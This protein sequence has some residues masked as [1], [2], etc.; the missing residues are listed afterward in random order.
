[1][2]FSLFVC[3][4]GLLGYGVAIR[5]DGAQISQATIQQLTADVTE[6]MTLTAQNANFDF[7]SAQRLVASAMILQ[8]GV[9]GSVTIE[10]LAAT[11]AM[12]VQATLGRLTLK[13]DDGNYYDVTVTADGTIHTENLGY[14]DADIVGGLTPAGK[15]VV[16]TEAA[17]DELNSTNIR[18]Q[19][20]IATQIFTRALQAEAISAS[21][22]FLA[23][24][25]IPELY[26][27]AIR[28]I[29]DTLE[30]SANQSVQIVVGN[31]VAEAVPEA[32]DTAMRDATPAVLRIDSSRGTVFKDGNVSTVLSVSIHYG[33][34]IIENTTAMRS[35]FGNGAYLQWEW[36][37]LDEDRYGVI[38][39]SDTRLSDGGFHF[40]L[41]PA[42]VDTKVTFR[43]SLITE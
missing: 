9:G 5:I 21:E 36:Q 2:V 24:A 23:S 41:S 33:S 12:F 40:T 34:Q 3:E 30:L 13:G 17:I 31:A 14:T 4:I 19:S 11:S 16:A 29:G 28:A 27:T 32:V 42:D 20:L 43:C 7:A 10:N 8:Q 35:A 15:P 6:T 37:R 18:A 38:S 39:A 26:V 22:A 25:T 1:M